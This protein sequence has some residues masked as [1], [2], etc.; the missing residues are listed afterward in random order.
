MSNDILEELRRATP[1]IAGAY[2]GVA[3]ST[4]L[5]WARED[6]SAET[7]K[8]LCNYANRPAALSSFCPMPVALAGR[9]SPREEDFDNS[10]ERVR[11]GEDPETGSPVWV[12]VPRASQDHV[13]DHLVGEAYAPGL[14]PY[15]DDGTDLELD[16]EARA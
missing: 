3:A 16:A 12:I 1:L 6:S 4:Q 10:I 9:K 2:A 15:V 8:A 7:Q 14:G 5:R 11:A 13:W